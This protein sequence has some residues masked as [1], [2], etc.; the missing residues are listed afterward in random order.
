MDLST[1]LYNDIQQGCTQVQPTVAP[2]MIQSR[3]TE[4]DTLQELNNRIEA[5]ND[6][7]WSLIED[8]RTA[9]I[10][11]KQL[12]DDLKTGLTPAAK[13]ALKEQSL[14]LSK[15]IGS[16]IC[17]KMSI[18]TQTLTATLDEKVDEAK[19]RIANSIRAE[20]E[21]ATHRL[22]QCSIILPQSVAI[23]LAV[24]LILSLS[25]N[26]VIATLNAM[27][28]HLPLLTNLLWVFLAAT[29]A[30]TMVITIAMR[31]CQRQ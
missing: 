16:S 23:I 7:L 31:W 29:V 6:D 10:T 30:I 12:I 3:D 24:T 14:R 18:V 11:S 5:L 1:D 20:T 13:I 21:Q 25:L 2:D 9:T 17:S 26:I 22:K 19:A 8:L 28:W 4:L 15:I 27:C